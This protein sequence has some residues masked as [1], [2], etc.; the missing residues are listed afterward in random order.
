MKRALA[1]VAAGLLC[2][3]LALLW[4]W[5]LWTAPWAPGPGGPE[6]AAA[7]TRQVRILPGMSFAAAADTL[8]AQ[9]LLRDPRVLRWGVRLTGRGGDLHAGLF[10]IPVGV[11]PRE[12]LRLLTE[13]RTVPVRVTVPEG[14]EAPATAE[15]VA[16]AL[17]FAADE[18][19]AHADAAARRV[20][21]GRGGLPRQFGAA[22]YDSLLAAEST[23]FAG[24]F[25]WSDGYLA[26]DTYHFAEG[27]TAEDAAA[28]LVMTQAARLDSV[29]AGPRGPATADLNAHELLTLASIVEAEARREDERPPWPTSPASAASACSTRTSRRRRRSTP[30]V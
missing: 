29:A 23:A 21:V 7:A 3:L 30:T 5:R 13:G 22:R 9:G 20:R 27:T 28:E 1:V 17:G 8:T 16:A 25:H 24:A 15:I 6:A 26:P 11:S 4:G 14:L 10:E 19:L 18:F 2:G 12:L